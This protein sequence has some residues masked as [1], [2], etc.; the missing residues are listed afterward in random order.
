MEAISKDQRHADGTVDFAI[1]VKVG[2]VV[3]QRIDIDNLR[4]LAFSI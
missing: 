3:I 2:S 4:K 1:P